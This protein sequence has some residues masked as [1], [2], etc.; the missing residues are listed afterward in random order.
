MSQAIPFAD[1]DLARRLEHAEG[2]GNVAFVEARATAQ[3]EV[4]A[5]WTTVGGAFAMFDGVGS[6]CTQTFGLGLA[7]P[8]GAAELDA[9]EDFFFSRGASVCHEVSPLAGVALFAL[10]ASRG[11]QPVE[12]STVL[13]QPLESAPHE[14]AAPQGVGHASRVKVRQVSMDEAAM[15]AGVSSRGWSESAEVRSFIEGLARLMV[16]RRDGPCF[17][18]EVDGSPI[19]TGAMSLWQ[20][21]ALLAGASTVPEGRRQGAQLALLD[22]RLRFAASQGCDLAMMCTAAGSTSQRNAERNG[23]RVGYTRVKWQLNHSD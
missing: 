14:G 3:P 1:L 12:L 6:P 22:T 4:G 10:L 7:D 13:F 21:V 23:F 16:A 20:G 15:F 17:V 11:Y 8:I 9:L 18:A 2:R 5:T 19:A